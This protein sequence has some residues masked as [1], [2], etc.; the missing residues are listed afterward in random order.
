MYNLILRQRI[1]ID[2]GTAN[3]L[4]FL[5]GKGIVLNEPTV[6][7][8]S[9]KDRKVIAVGTNAKQMIGKSPRGIEVKRPLKQG[10]IA[11]YKFT[12]ALLRYLIRTS[13]GRY[14]IFKPDVMIA[15]PAGLTSVE[16][17][18]VMEAAR[19]AGVSKVYLLPEP[20]AAAI[21]AHIPISSSEGNMIINMGGGTS[22]IAVISLNGLVQYE[23]KRLAGDAINQTLQ[24]FLKK[25]YNLEVGELMAEQVKINIGAAIPLDNPIGMLVRGRNTI[26][27]QPYGIELSSNEIMLPI[28]SVLN[29]IIASVK[30]VLEKTPPELASD[31]VDR[32]V[33]LSGGTALIRGIDNF[34]ADALGVPAHVVENP[35]TAV[36][37]GVAASLNYI[38]LLNTSLS[39]K[40]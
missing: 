7:A 21:G 16:E 18:A 28:T 6:L 23:S 31:I 32:G 8:Y 20:L 40:D 5:E 4:V 13:L 33:V 11:S 1:A 37:E 22:E 30:N 26:T 25:K 2:L 24:A 38:D 19:T 14:R 27:G 39:W 29:E 34:F 36:V 12:Q 3:S 15:V 10:V 35:L 17:R 9:V